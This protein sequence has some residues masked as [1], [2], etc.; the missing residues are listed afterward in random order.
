MDRQKVEFESLEYKQTHFSAGRE[1]V[2]YTLRGYAAQGRGRKHRKQRSD[3]VE[4]G[5]MLWKLGLCA[6]VCALMLLMN[7]HEINPT[8]NADAQSEETP[9][10]TPVEEMGKLR[11]VELPGLISVFS[12]KDQQ[13]FPITCSKYTLLEDDTLLSIVPDS[14]QDVAAMEDCTVKAVG[15]DESKGSYVTLRAAKDKEWTLYGMQDVRV[16]KGQSLYAQDTIGTVQ[17]GETVYITLRVK[18]RPQDMR[19]VFGLDDT[20]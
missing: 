10:Q 19:A 17:K 6:G 16:E 11:F 14:L 9:T 8:E 4:A 1:R 2:L 5:S 12:Q 13:A 7:N 20:L 15:N 3:A 18:G